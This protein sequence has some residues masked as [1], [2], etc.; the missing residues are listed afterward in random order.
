LRCGF[1][2]HAN[3]FE[4]SPFDT[5]IPNSRVEPWVRP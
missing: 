4:V 1:E 2:L 5:A 3:L